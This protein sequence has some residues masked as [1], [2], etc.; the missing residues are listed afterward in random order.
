MKAYVRCGDV[1]YALVAPLSTIL[2][3]ICDHLPARVRPPFER[4]VKLDRERA[5]GEHPFDRIE[6]LELA[7]S[8]H[9]LLCDPPIPIRKLRRIAVGPLPAA[10]R[11]SELRD[12]LA[13][14]VESD[15]IY[16]L[17]RSISAP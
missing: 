15:V 6:L 10:E 2:A 5:P 13:A 4:I 17:W 3:A 1:E 12:W 14:R 16:D 7:A 9:G 11:V 8:A